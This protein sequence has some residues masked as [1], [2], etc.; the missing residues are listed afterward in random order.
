MNHAHEAA[1]AGRSA[2]TL[3]RHRLHGA[4]MRHRLQSA[5][6]AL[7][8]LVIGFAALLLLAAPA[9]AQQ[10]VPV[11]TGRIVDQA[12]LFDTAQRSALEAQLATIESTSGAQLV[13]LTLATTQPEDIADYTQ[14][15]ADAWKLGRREVGDGLLIVVARDDRRVRIAVAKALEG[16][17]PDLA[18]RQII[19]NTLRPAFRAGDWSGGIGRAVEQLD[20]RIRGE[21]LPLPEP[22]E[23]RGS[24]I[25]AQFEDLGLFL[26]IAV[27]MAAMLIT[28][29]FGRK[30]GSLLT[31]GAAG[32]AAW[33]FSHSMALAIGAGLVTLFIVGL[34]GIGSALGRMARGASRGGGGWSSGT[35]WGGG[36]GWS[37]GGSGGFSSG[38]G[39]DFGG[40]GASGDW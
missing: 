5:L 21:N 30:L 29:L 33:W 26:F 4:P 23:S 2:S 27:P 32:G 14:R 10:P 8:A 3:L 28:R 20:A 15:V 25:G 12:G 18:A 1:G 34:L 11:L 31:A 6:A 39:G 16:A 24:G 35:S 36:G 9:S 40:G 37:S 38:G 13:V 7:A 22:R 17:V 19:D